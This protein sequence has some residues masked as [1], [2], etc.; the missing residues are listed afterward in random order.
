MAKRPS[1]LKRSAQANR[2]AKKERDR[3]I[4]KL[5]DYGLVTKRQNLKSAVTRRNLLSKYKDVLSGK[6]VVV[7]VPKG[8]AA[9]LKSSMRVVGPKVVVPRD[10]GEK[11]K[12]EKRDQRLTSTRKVGGQRVKRIVY[13]GGA[14]PKP[15]KGKKFMYAVPF[16]GGGRVRFDSFAALKDF[17]QPYHTYKNWKDYLEIEE[18][19]AGEDEGEGGDG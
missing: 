18:V 19:D 13:T 10:R 15:K 4:Q 16:T 9:K 6:A 5:K 8:F 11:V 17:M 1:L 7:T 14:M 3:Q 2:R 12:F